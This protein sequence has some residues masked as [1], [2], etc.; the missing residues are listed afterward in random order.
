MFCVH[1]GSTTG[2]LCF[3]LTS[4]PVGLQRVGKTIVVA[5]MDNSLLC[6]TTKVWQTPGRSHSLMYYR[7]HY[8]SQV[9]LCDGGL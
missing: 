5:C 4:Q 2:R 6:Y 7:F 1:R 9:G 8:Y 3:E